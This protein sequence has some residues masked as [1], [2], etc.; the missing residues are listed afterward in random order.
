MS[1]GNDFLELINLLW[2]IEEFDMWLPKEH[3]SLAYLMERLYGTDAYAEKYDKLK[4]LATEKKANEL[5]NYISCEI[6]ASAQNDNTISESDKLNLEAMLVRQQKNYKDK[7]LTGFGIIQE[8]Y[9]PD[10]FFEIF[11]SYIM[12]EE[13]K[14]ETLILLYCKNEGMNQEQANEAYKRLST[15]Y[16]LLNEFYFYVKNKRFKNH[17]PRTVKKLSAK[18]LYETICDTPLAAYLYL[19]YLRED[20]EKAFAEYHVKLNNK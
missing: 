5:A 13:T 15:Q 17:Y 19:V 9:M 7:A 14:R 11:S 20:P 2:E 16:D 1:L 6:L 12:L 18:S 8:K 4:S 3:G 10:W